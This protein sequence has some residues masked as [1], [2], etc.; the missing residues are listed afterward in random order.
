MLVALVPLIGIYCA[1][2]SYEDF[3]QRRYLMGA[4]GAVGAAGSLLVLWLWLVLSSP[5]RGI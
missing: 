2:K 3:K 4:W 5:G 1:I